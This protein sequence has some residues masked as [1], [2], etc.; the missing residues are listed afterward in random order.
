MSAA[1]TRQSH[2]HSPPVGGPNGDG[3][4]QDRLHVLVLTD[5][6]WTHPQ[7][8]GTG[9]NLFGQVSRWL[10]WGHRVTIVA[11]GYRGCTP[12][13]RIDALTIHRVGGRSTV[14]PRAIMRQWRGL[15][16]DADVVLEVVNGIT[17]LTPLWLRTPRVTLVHHIHRD[18]YVREMGTAGRVAALLLETLPLKLLYRRSQFLTI[19][20]ASADDIA[21]LGLPRERIEV[22]YIGVEVDAFGRDPSLR[23]ERPTLLYLGRLKRYKRIEIVLDALAANPDAVLELAGDGDYR[24]DLEAAIRERGLA[25]RVRMHGHVSEQRKREL[26]QQAWVNVTA[27]S[28]EGWCL[29]VMEAAASG[30]PTV[31]LAVGGLPESIDDG[32]TGLLA[33]DPDDLARKIGQVLHDPELRD[34][35]G[36]AAY[37]RALEFTWDATASGTLALLERQRR[38]VPAH[39]GAGAA[40]VLAPAAM[41]PLAIAGAGSGSNGKGARAEV[42]LALER[43]RGVEGWLSD[44]Q[45]ARLFNRAREVLPGG[46]IVEI[47]SYRGRSTIVLATGAADGVEVIAIDPHA[48]N[49]RGP[50]EIEGYSA[51]AEQDNTAFHANLERATVAGRVL[52]VRRPSQEALGEVSGKVDVLYVDG[53]HRFDPASRDIAGWGDRVRPGGTMLIH[54]SFSSI[55]VTLAILRLLLFGRDFRYAGRTRSLAE[56]HRAERPLSIGERARNA[57]RQLAELPWFARNVAVKLALVARLRPLARALGHSG[58]DWPY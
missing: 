10:A 47:G 9:T 4:P 36:A 41:L 57:V 18:H 30:T 16:P 31:A 51:E 34:R 6:D 22:G 48:G 24:D 5:R 20:Q 37:E 38:H 44:D 27:S 15:V 53:A 11:C 42:D 50:Q 28:A 1:P 21:R 56:Y 29:S 14:F 26:L 19:S 12:F 43:A 46:R 39:V 8:G 58:G 2:L 40:A 45:A 13:E 3:A 7:G 17:F 32:R 25:E 33:D 54:D 52:H 23:A 35:L 55:G 49:D